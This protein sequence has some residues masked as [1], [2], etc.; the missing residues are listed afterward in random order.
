[1]CRVLDVSRSGYYAWLKRAPS[2]RD[3]E[4]D[5]LKERIREIHRQSRGTY[6]VPRIHAELKEDD[7]RVGR[8]RIARL[9]REEGLRGV[10]FSVCL[11]GAL[12]GLRL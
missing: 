12:R 1:M 2:A 8:K 3:E 7:E 6:G 10:E 9:M 11:E 5:R 4:D